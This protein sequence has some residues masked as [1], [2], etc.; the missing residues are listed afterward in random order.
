MSCSMPDGICCKIV[1]TGP[2]LGVLGAAKAQKFKQALK[3]FCA[4]K[5]AEK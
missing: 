1:I 2:K 5:I 3:K 4:K